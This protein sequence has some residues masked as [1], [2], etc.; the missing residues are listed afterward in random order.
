MDKETNNTFLKQIFPRF[1]LFLRI[2]R[3]LLLLL[4]FFYRMTNFPMDHL[5]GRDSSSMH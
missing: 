1:C 3:L 2:I 4:F 5:P